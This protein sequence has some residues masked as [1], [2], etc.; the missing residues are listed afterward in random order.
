MASY[1]LH[2]SVSGLSVFP[3]RFWFKTSFIP[4]FVRSRSPPVKCARWRNHVTGR[5]CSSSSWVAHTL[6][7][8]VTIVIA[9]NNVVSTMDWRCVP[10][11]LLV[12]CVEIGS[13]KRGRRLTRLSNRSRSARRQ[14]SRRGHTIRWPTPLNCTHPRTRGLQA[15]PVKR[16]DDG[17]TRQK[18]D[19]AGKDKPA[20]LSKR[21]H[22]KSSKTVSSSVSVADR[23]SRS[24]SPFGTRGSDR[25]RSHS[26]E[27]GHRDHHRG[28]SRHH[29]SP[30]AKS[31]RHKHSP[32]RHESREQTR[33]S[34]SS[35]RSRSRSRHGVDSTD[36]PGSTRA[37]SKATDSRPSHHHQ[38]RGTVDHRSL[39]SQHH[40]SCHEK[41][42]MDHPG[43]THVSRKEI[44]MTTTVPD[45]PE[46][47]T[48]TVIQSPPGPASEDDWAG[49]TGP[50]EVADS[51]QDDGSARPVDSSVVADPAG[52]DDSAGVADPAAVGGQARTADSA[53]IADPAGQNVPAV[54]T[55]AGSQTPAQ[56]PQDQEPSSEEGCGIFPLLPRRI[57]QANP[58]D[59]M[60]IMTV[61]QRH[62]DNVTSGPENPDR[63]P[64][65]RRFIDISLSTYRTG[66]SQAP[67]R[68]S[69]A[70]VRRCKDFDDT[71][72][73]T[74]SRSPVRRSS[75]P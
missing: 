62:M 17:S 64:V 59:F 19:S 69:R 68:R 58:L 72:G 16:K 32:R 52:G 38:S 30:R 60:S 7:V 3:R 43:S 18:N 36:H 20:T 28:S 8:A 12:T 26:D 53:R 33:P 66:E 37:T 49:S 51:A 39:P 48:I 45:Q 21:S 46:R 47:R 15:P 23:P 74:R 61:M 44:D 2:Q 57:N 13:R 1:L 25:H 54:V 31:A 35:G 67:V 70:P 24:D 41:D 22:E 55:P 4:T 63:P 71:R 65:E 34:S 42:S 29:E 27:R 10:E 9:V 40:S 11:N 14:P 75:S 6:G 5:L 56:Q 73:S 50:A